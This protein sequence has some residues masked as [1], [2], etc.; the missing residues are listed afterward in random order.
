MSNVE[1]R[2]SREAEYLPPF[3]VFK[4][5]GLRGAVTQPFPINC[6]E[7][8]NSISYQEDFRWF[9]PSIRTKIATQ[10]ETSESHSQER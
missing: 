1:C 8:D 9:H 10:D 5:G 2:M 4:M 3:L 6:V 7:Q